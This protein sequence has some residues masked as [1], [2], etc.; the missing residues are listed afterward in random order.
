MQ[1]LLVVFLTSY[2]SN[3]KMMQP[4][5]SPASPS[6]LP[7]PGVPIPK[8]QMVWVVVQSRAVSALSSRQCYSSQEQGK[9]QGGSLLCASQMSLLPK[10]VR[11][12]KA[13]QHS[14]ARAFKWGWNKGWVQFNNKSGTSRGGAQGG[15]YK[16]TTIWVQRRW[17]QLN[18]V[19]SVLSNRGIPGRSLGKGLGQKGLTGNFLEQEVE[20]RKDWQLGRQ[21]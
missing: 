2:N 12:E 19:Y 10:G 3:C 6:L 21:V 15:A 9:E 1:I 5:S 18:S 4:E 11:K 8:S 16:I 14:F 20:L 13:T 7:V 17:I